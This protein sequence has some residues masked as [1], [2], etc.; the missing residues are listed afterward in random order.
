MKELNSIEVTQVAGGANE[1]RSMYMNMIEL[2]H[3]IAGG[4]IGA[5]L[6]SSALTV[7]VALFT[8]RI[9]LTMAGA[10]IGGAV[11]EILFNYA[12]ITS[13]ERDNCLAAL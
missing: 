1:P 7:P 10:F 5:S 9:P 3:I 4:G 12:I 11:G 6:A 8:I 13:V 2:V